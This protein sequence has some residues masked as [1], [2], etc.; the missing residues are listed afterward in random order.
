[1]NVVFGSKEFLILFSQ[2]ELDSEIEALSITIEKQ[3]ATRKS[4]CVE[5]DC[6]F[7]E[8][9]SKKKYSRAKDSCTL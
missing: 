1:M 5:E 6:F 3:N 9:S 8:A 4:V 2:W 7:Y